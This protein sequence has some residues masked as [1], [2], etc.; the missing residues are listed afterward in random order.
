MVEI[1]VTQEEKDATRYYVTRMA[2]LNEQMNIAINEMPLNF[3]KSKEMELPI[4][5]TFKSIEM[6]RQAYDMPQSAYEISYSDKRFMYIRLTV[7]NI[8]FQC[9]LIEGEE[10]YEDENRED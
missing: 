7:F 3:I 2:Y 5:N 6:I 4:L 8:R 9:I 1:E 10:G